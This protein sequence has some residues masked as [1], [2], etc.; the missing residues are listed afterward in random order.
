MPSWHLAW[1]T[2]LYISTNSLH[3]NVQCCKHVTKFWNTKTEYV[4]CIRVFK[5]VLKVT[6]FD[7]H[8]KTSK[9]GTLIL[10]R[11]LFNTTILGTCFKTSGV[12]FSDMILKFGF[13]IFETV[14]RSIF[15]CLA[16]TT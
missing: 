6:Y 15:C 9:Q 11:F 14:K 16:K 10:P 2:V 8:V 4:I 7:Q 5:C 12:F 3:G 13:H 1:D